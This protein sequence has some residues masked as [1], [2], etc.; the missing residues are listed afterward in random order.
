MAK[1]P[2]IK[3]EQR[4]NIVKKIIINARVMEK[5]FNINI[6][7][8][9]RIIAFIFIDYVWLA[10]FLNKDIKPCYQIIAFI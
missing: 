3:D 1:L 8:C 5:K 7:P 4:S 9:F 6:K 10:N 2:I